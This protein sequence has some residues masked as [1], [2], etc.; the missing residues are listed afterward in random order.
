MINVLHISHYP[1]LHMGGQQS[2]FA[3][4]ENLNTENI[5]SYALLPSKGELSNVLE[6]IGCECFFLPLCSLKLKNI[7]NVISNIKKLHSIIKKYN[8]DIVHCDSER[9]AF[10]SII[11]KKYT[12]CK[13]IYHLRLTRK[14]NLDNIIVRNSD[15]LIGISEGTRQRIPIKFQS[16]FSVIFNGVDT[17]KFIPIDDS[18]KIKIKKELNFP[19]AKFNI[20]FVG[21][22]KYGK[23]I[24]ELIEA[25]KILNIKNLDFSISFVGEFESNEFKNI[26]DTKIKDYNLE[27]KCYFYGY[28]NNIYK[29]MQVA[30]VLVLPSYEGVEGMGRVVFEAMACG[31]PVVASDISGV[32]EAITEETGILVPEK[33]PYLLADAFIK[34]K[35]IEDRDNKFVELCHRHAKD[36]FDITKHSLSIEKIYYNLLNK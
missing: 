5:K 20:L 7:F 8:I 17:N 31:I 29:F 12:K 24:I 35:N 19:K 4:I 26:I 1:T 15:Y 13:L 16:K 2:M 30:D 27:K 34:L 10:I 22:I 36:N 23:G 28:Y 3:L 21:Q 33:S 11:A 18:S 25:A 9:D 14:N 6:G 32:R